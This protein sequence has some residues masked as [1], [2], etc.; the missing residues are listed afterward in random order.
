MHEVA[1]GWVAYKLGDPTAKSM[2]RLTLN[3]IAHIDPFG[4][5]L[6]PLI[7]FIATSGKF[8]FGSAKPVPVNFNNLRNPKRDMA[9][10]A[11]AG[12]AA[13]V[14]ISI[15]SIILLKLL[16]RIFA[17]VNMSGVVAMVAVPVISMLQYSVAFNIFLAAFN[18]LPIPPLDG[19][20]IAVSLLPY[21]QAHWLSRVE[22]YGI[23]IVLILWSLGIA[24]YIIDPIQ[25]FIFFIVDIFGRI[26]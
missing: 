3:P 14:L 9:L 8:M 12:P 21:K 20:R 7:L 5:V 18:L 2:G 25:A 19:G 24:R 26:F 23:F 11:A 17:T 6:L 4:T 13:N 16:G 1:H 22:P 15:L 10:V